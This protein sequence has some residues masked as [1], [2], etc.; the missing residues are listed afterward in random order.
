LRQ[1]VHAKEPEANITAH[2]GIM[3]IRKLAADMTAAVQQFFTKAKR[4]YYLVMLF[5]YRCPNCNGSLTM[6]A[7]SICRCK[8]CTCEFDPTVEFQRCLHCG[9]APVLRVRRYQCNDCGGDITSM[10]L[11]DGLVFNAEYFH[12]KMAES[13][14]RKKEQKQRVQ[15]MLSECRS[16]PLTLDVPDLSS[17]PGLIDA[18][19]G[20]T[21][22][23]GVSIELE[24][25]NEFDLSRYQAHI[26]SHLR[27]EPVSLRQIPPLMEN[28]RLD[29][30]WKFIA[31]IFLDHAGV[32]NI[33]QQHETVWVMKLDDREGQNIPGEAEETDGFERLESRTQPW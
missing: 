21:D 33:R 24:L 11:F 29:L 4:F 17:V 3:D 8:L 9:G 16:E 20:L 26:N 23:L 12:Q 13:R 15:Q 31:A 18:L 27:A 1:E 6:V 5:G 7:E 22:G 14:R 25:R 30:I 2:G 19:N 10:F 28:E 32:I